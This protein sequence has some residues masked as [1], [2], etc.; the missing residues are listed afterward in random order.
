MKILVGID[1]SKNAHRA[2]EFA[3]KHFTLKYTGLEDKYK[4]EYAEFVNNV[5]RQKTEEI[6]RNYVGILQRIAFSR[7]YNEVQRSSIEVQE[8]RD[9]REI[10]LRLVSERSYDCI[11]V[12]RRGET[13]YERSHA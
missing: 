5:R 11:V 12:G 7:H 1:G 2:F 9:A 4:H 6:F 13:D 8:G 3:L 10:L